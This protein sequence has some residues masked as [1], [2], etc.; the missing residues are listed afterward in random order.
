MKT[1]LQYVIS[2]LNI[3]IVSFYIFSYLQLKFKKLYLQSKYF[4]Y[5]VFYDFFYFAL[6][7]FIL[8]VRLLTCISIC[9]E[10]AGDWPNKSRKFTV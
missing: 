6:A 4:P 2:N 8:A 3:L 7:T 10:K 9:Y 5:Y 1:L